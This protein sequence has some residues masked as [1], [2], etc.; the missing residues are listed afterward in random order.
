[1]LW[2]FKHS[3]LQPLFF[4]IFTGNWTKNLEAVAP[5]II[6]PLFWVRPLNFLFGVYSATADWN[7]HWTIYFIEFYIEFLCFKYVKCIYDLDNCLTACIIAHHQ[8]RAYSACSSAF[9]LRFLRCLILFWDDRKQCWFL[10]NIVLNPVFRSLSRLCMYWHD[11]KTWKKPRYQS[12]VL[13][14]LCLL[15]PNLW[16][17]CCL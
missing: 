4:F 8:L 6:R 14:S 5:Q 15:F 11:S 17:I 3:K 7:K 13:S 1:M 16:N 2:G 12:S 10:N 9:N